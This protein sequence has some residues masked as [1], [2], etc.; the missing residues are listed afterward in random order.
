VS[1]FLLILAAATQPAQPTPYPDKSNLLY[2]L[3]DNAERAPID[4]TQDWTRRRNHI[5]QN[6]QRVMGP[7][8]DKNPPMLDIQVIEEE[9]LDGYTRRR[10]TFAVEDWDRL[11]AYLL[12][13][14]DIDT[15][16]PAMVCLHPTNTD[17]KDMVVGLVDKPNRDYAHELAQRGYV[18]IAPDY[19]GFGEYKEERKELYER[20]Y[21]SGTMKG[22]WNHMRSVD[23]LQS[24]PYVD[25]DRIGAIGHSLGGHNALYLAA[26][27]PRIKVIVTSCGFNSFAKYYGGDL[28]GW[29]HDGYM[30]RIATE[31]DRDPAKMPFDFTEVLGLMA[32]RPVFINAPL[33]D[34]NFEVSGVRDCVQAAKPV[35]ELYSATDNLVAKY[36]DAGHDFPPDIRRQ[37]YEFIDDALN[38]D[39]IAVSNP[40]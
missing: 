7:M 9:Q 21:V 36:P 4:S 17:G 16:A 24:L 32:P 34:A 20:G 3:N 27:D 25:P 30:P 31:Y 22:I 1:I 19:H 29:S 33:N 10:I 12:I 39:D 23:L 2:Y 26:F 28:T 13:P 11:P 35:Y 15:Q 14:D 6:M 37:A 18:C 5:L 38:M 40:R 8:P